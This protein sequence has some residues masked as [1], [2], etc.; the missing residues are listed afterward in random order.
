M[1]VLSESNPT[2]VMKKDIDNGL[3]F[4]LDNAAKIYPA[5]KDRELTS[6]FRVGVELKDRV[7]AGKFLEAVQA[8]EDRFPYFKVRLKAGFFWYYLEPVAAGV[9]V[10]VDTGPP[11]RAFDKSGL[12][13][14]VLV[15]ENKI[16]VE[17]SHIL[18]D[19]TGA[20][21][22]LKT[23]LGVYF[24]KCCLPAASGF[25]YLKPGEAPHAEESTDAYNHYFK[26][27]H[28]RPVKVPAAFHV[29][30]RLKS[31]P[32]FDVLKAVVPIKAIVKKAKEYQVSL[33][34]Y[35]T[36]VYLHSLQQIF[37]QSTDIGKRISHKIL[38]IEVPVNLRR[39]FPSRTMRNFSLYVIPGIDR[40]LG[41]FTFEEI[42]KTVYHQMQLETDKKLISKMISRNVS[43]ERN[44]FLR[45]VPLFIKSLLMAKLYTLGTKE[46]SGV[47]TNLGKVDLGGEVN[48]L[49]DNFIFI[50]P[51]PNNVLRVNCAVV[52]FEDKL[53]LAFG[54]I[55]R[56]K[57]LERLFL[58]FLAKS[59]IPVKIVK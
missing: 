18:T 49:I 23:L 51:P 48:A 52:G 2:A 35:L 43:G 24:E 36:A 37:E 26:K 15:R 53:M 46:Y 1:W 17:F 19:G 33:T 21:E 29:P 3:W 50:P 32:R 39:M 10:G 28:A 56:S 20:F 54:N 30:F 57:E 11:C 45:R 34:E 8:I 31:S 12:M 22:Y 58:T 25:S 13:F 16:S 44:A 27:I 14:R 7:R 9:A 47:V 38:R 59:G 6:V 55:T 41:H 42:V 40:R 4:R 5:I